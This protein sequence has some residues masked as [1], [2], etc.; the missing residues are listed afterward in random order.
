MFLSIAP[1]LEE[2]KQR[3]QLAFLNNAA[4]SPLTPSE[5]LSLCLLAEGA[6]KSSNEMEDEIHNLEVELNA[7][8]READRFEGEADEWRLKFEELADEINNVRDEVKREL[9][10][11]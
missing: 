8:E 5:A 10:D 9:A 2:L 7:V 3:V 6:R 11:E 1:D 4:V